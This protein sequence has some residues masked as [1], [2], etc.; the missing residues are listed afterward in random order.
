MGTEILLFILC[1]ILLVSFLIERNKRQA[2]SK[3]LDVENYTLE[4]TTMLMD[5]VFKN[6]HAFIILIDDDFAVLKTNYYMLTGT[7]ATLEKKRVGDL[8]HCRNAMCALHGC[9][10]GEL[11]KTCPIRHAIQNA[12]DTKSN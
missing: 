8:L 1:I 4:E 7:I 11:C 5:A 10:T 6:V 2:Y 9:G 12:L 3:H